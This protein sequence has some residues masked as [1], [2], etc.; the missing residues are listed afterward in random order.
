MLENR[1]GPPGVGVYACAYPLYDERGWPNSLKLPRG[2]KWPPPKG[3]TGCDGAT[4]SAECKGGAGRDATRT[5]AEW[6][7][8]WRETTLAVADCKDSTR[9]LYT[10]LS[11]KHLEPA[12]F[13]AI[14]LDRLRP[15]DIEALIDQSAGWA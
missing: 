3:F 13:G 2:Q 5:V 9:S 6:L 11:R 4:P 15:S 14:Q 7:A 12:P 8:Q 1:N 10:T